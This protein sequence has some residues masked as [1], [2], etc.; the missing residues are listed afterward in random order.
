[1]LGRKTD[2][3]FFPTPLHPLNN[4]SK[5]Y[6]NY[7]VYIKRDDHTGLA[8]GGN[9]VRKLEYLLQ[10]ALNQG[11]QLILTAGSQQ[12]NHCRQTAAA[13]AKLGLECH[14]MMAGHAPE[15]FTGNLLLSKLLG[16]NFHFTGQGKKGGDTQQLKNKL[17]KQNKK[18]FVI[19]LGGSTPIGALGFVHAIKELKEQLTKQKLN[20]DYLFFGSSSGSTQAGLMLGL[21]LFGLNIE[22]IPINIDKTSFN[23]V[24][25]EE[26]ILKLINE[27]ANLLSID[28]VYELSDIP[29]VR[30]YSKAG[31]GVITG[32]EKKAIQELGEK[33][34]I[35][36]DPI[37]TA[38]TF[39]G[40]LDYLK[41][42]KIEANTN[43]L[44]WHTGGFPEI[45]VNPI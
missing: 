24:T 13:C 28:R 15:K 43:I 19:P 5:K 18:C 23:G 38:R 35:L 39:G 3:G 34:G 45:F 17:E 32:L 6:P 4:I 7:T 33:E 1:M 25:L 31:Y 30:D 12:S 10:E 40:M 2:L 29:L 21:E 42:K 14:L 20:I 22:L 9:K 16:A 8:S 11:C 27:G 36:L 44:F 37:Y 26:K 41:K